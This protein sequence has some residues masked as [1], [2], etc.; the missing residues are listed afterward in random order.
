MSLKGLTLVWERAWPLVGAAA[1]VW[2][3]YALGHPF[4]TN[5]DSLFGTAATVSSIFASFLGVSK[6]IILTIKGTDT[7]KV[8]EQRGYTEL[9]FAYLRDGIFASVL[10]ASGSIL[11]FFVDHE[12]IV[13][14]HHLF[15][16]F[17]L[18]WV[19]AGS[20]SLLTYIRITNILF[21]LLK[22]T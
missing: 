5:P 14:K 11:G 1:I 21:K 6:A 19:F 12:V 2:V 10:F 9:L 13:W 17:E 3:W 20:L 15:K 4:P 22:L 7:Y 16:L 8:L 18:I